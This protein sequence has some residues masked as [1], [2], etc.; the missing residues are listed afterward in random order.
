MY[1]RILSFIK[2]NACLVGVAAL[3]LAT[4]GIKLFFAI[5]LVVFFAA[6]L[7]VISDV[8]V[9]FSELIQYVF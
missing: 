8:V 1:S 6:G 5:C 2:I 9:M 7:L 4:L 3:T